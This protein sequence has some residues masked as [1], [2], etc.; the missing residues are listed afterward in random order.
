MEQLLSSRFFVVCLK[1]GDFLGWWLKLFFHFKAIG[2]ILFL[3][4]R[5]L[6]MFWLCSRLRFGVNL[7][8]IGRIISCASRV[9]GLLSSAKKAVVEMWASLF[10]WEFSRIRHGGTSHHSSADTVSSAIIVLWLLYLIAL[11]ILFFN[12]VFELENTSQFKFLPGSYIHILF[13]LLFI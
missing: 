1:Q 8:N 6:I 13:I 10:L 9:V 11:I 2:S 7:L 4:Q 3:L 5:N 12:L